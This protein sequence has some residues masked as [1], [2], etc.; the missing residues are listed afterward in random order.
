MSK[1]KKIVLIS[2]SIVVL[3][4][5]LVVFLFFFSLRATGSGDEIVNFVVTSGDSKEE[6]TDNLKE[7]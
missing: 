4:I 7:A 5:A 6:I 1:L 2:S 3:V